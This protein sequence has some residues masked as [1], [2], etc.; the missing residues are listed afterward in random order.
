MASTTVGRSADR[1]LPSTTSAT[2]SAVKAFDAS[3]ASIWGT[4][5]VRQGPWARQ[6]RRR[7]R[8]SGVPTAHRALTGC[9]D[10]HLE[11]AGPAACQERCQLLVPSV[12]QGADL[13]CATDRVQ[14]IPR[15]ARQRA[16]PCFALGR[17]GLH[18]QLVPAG[19][20]QR[21]HP[22]GRQGLGDGRRAGPDEA[23]V[24]GRGHTT[25]LTRDHAVPARHANAPRDPAPPPPGRTRASRP[26][27]PPPPPGAAP[28]RPP[29]LRETQPGHAAPAQPPRRPA[30][31]SPRSRGRHEGATGLRPDLG[32]EL[33]PLLGAHVRR[34]GNDQVDGAAQPLGE[35]LEPAALEQPDRGHMPGRGRAERHEVVLG[36]TQRRGT[37]VGG[38]DLGTAGTELRRQRQGD[39]TGSRTGVDHDQ[40][41]S[42]FGET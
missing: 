34:V 12:G 23:G 6:R 7:S 19:G 32:V 2:W 36:H 11:R 26:G 13:A 38:P 15:V 41:R 24:V 8:R 31:A 20:G 14:G 22:S 17:T 25:I 3:A 37:R 5:T 35:R 21:H 42:P 28:A 10:H 40:T 30:R 4:A 9:G 29:R 39:G 1:G 33:P 16:Q 18:H 27:G